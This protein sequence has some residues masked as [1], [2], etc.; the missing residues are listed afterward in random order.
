MLSVSS[1]RSA[2]GAANY[3][4]KDDYYTGEHSSEM[5]EWGGAGAADLGLAGEVGKEA[6]EGLL[7]GRL[8]DGGSIS[9]NARHRPGM[10][11]T[12]SM[13]KSLSILAYVAGDERILEAYRESVR[14]TMAWVE[15][16][17]AEGRIYDRDGKNGEA[18]G[19]SH[20]TYAMFQHDTSRKL[21]PQG[22]IHVVV[23]NATRVEGQWRALRN[24]PLWANNTV[25][26]SRQSADFRNRVEKLGYD[27][28]VTGKHG[29]FDAVG[30][31][32]KVVLDSFSQRRIEILDKINDLGIVTPQGRDAVTIGTR[33]NKID[34]EDR[35]ALRAE[36]RERA[37]ALGFDGKQVVEA[38]SAR[39]EASRGG[40]E[41]ITSLSQAARMSSEV[42]GKIRGRLEASSSG[43]AEFALGAL[44]AFE[45]HL[46]GQDP[47]VTSGLARLALAPSDLRTQ[48]AVASAIRI[49]GQRDA[50]FPLHHVSKVA[51]DLGLSGVTPEKV[52][53]RIA[54]LAAQGQL[55][56]GISGRRDERVTHVTTP[57]LVQDEKRLLA[58]VD[59]GKGQGV[60][61][62]P[63][64]QV[65]DRL[66]DKAGQLKTLDAAPMVLNGEQLAAATLAL[67]SQD[68]TVVIQ[69]VAGAGKSTMVYALSRVA[70]D[71][72]KKVLGLA[73]ANKMVNMLR[74]DG[75]I[76]A[77]TVASFVRAHL[78][79]A[80][81]GK[82]PNFEASRAALADMV[83]MFD[84]A[85][86]VA[87]QSMNDMVT[88]ANRLNIDRLIMMGDRSQ[89][90]AVDAGKPYSLVQTH[91]QAEISELKT[92]QR[93]KTEHMK[94]VATLSRQGNYRATFRVLGDRVVSVGKE[95]RDT[96]AKKW[97]EL[98]ADD[99]ERTALY[100][101]G[102]ET[103][104]YLNE[105]VQQGL[106]AEG[107]ISGEG[108]EIRRLESLNLTREE[109][110]YAHHY[111][112]GHQL[113][114]TNNARPGGLARGAYM[115][116]GVTKRGKVNLV[117]EHGRKHSFHPSRIDPLDTR[118]T[119]ALS[120][121][122]PITVHAGD[123]IVWTANDRERGIFN[124]ARARILAITPQGVEV[125]LG[126]GADM[127]LLAMGDK[128]LERMNLAYAINM[129]Q[130]QGMT[131]DRGI[132]VMSAN[133]RQLSN[134]RLTHV[135]L[136]RVRFDIA[137]YTDD[138]MQLLRSIEANPGDKAS[139]LE[140]VGVKN[141]RK[142]GPPGVPSGS[143]LVSSPDGPDPFAKVDVRFD[144]EIGK[145]PEGSKAAQV[146]KLPEKDIGL[147]L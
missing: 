136:T 98:S 112:A 70:E 142:P 31:V 147:S 56:E 82:G 72:G 90:Q 61:L 32:P 45:E 73:M 143:H 23:L 139:A 28:Q 78:K 122:D 79:P 74:E 80:I 13:P 65:I 84:E 44:H 40:E 137:I 50:A 108:V 36:W 67:T 26:G 71:Q 29:Q 117:D 104:A 75:Q 7:N 42:L 115:V 99:R 135:M 77:Q 125:R 17:F 34:L 111:K 83:L 21:D 24:D 89:L 91:S 140:A 124:S 4:T 10:D 119:L 101:S 6:F 54:Q 63:S 145:P 132:G 69:G 95:Y 52:D 128:M 12:F 35:E 46:K 116:V 76:E 130:A 43:L 22:H 127:L 113:E 133:E 88:I 121:R 102:R 93:Q 59:A 14:A 100:A 58:G 5:S 106:R 1:I 16:N 110:R 18:I 55:I 8:P 68:R 107:T 19:T 51:L 129:H 144:L 96:A 64:D 20:L 15:K 94:A 3:F 81:E 62:I 37:A 39:S 141:T 126:E 38:A 33:D 2:G 138:K 49:L 97:L 87:N 41:K 131:T 60:A 120:A 25:I 11:L 114:V 86:L 9:G 85:S 53:A 146:T 30:V 109:L 123:K 92:S 47:L 66:Q 48:M 27:T 134:Q 118:D 105:V 103:R 57:Q